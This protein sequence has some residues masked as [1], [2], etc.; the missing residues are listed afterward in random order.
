M[1]ICT[2]QGVQYGNIFNELPNPK[3]KK[4]SGICL[5]PPKVKSQYL[6]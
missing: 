6:F 1:K 4:L 3:L 2:G 5:T